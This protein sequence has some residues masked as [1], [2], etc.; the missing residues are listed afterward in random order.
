MTKIRSIQRAMERKILQIKLKDKIPHRDIGKK[1]TNFE[2]VLKQI[3][4]QKWR[5]AGHVGRMHGNGWTKRCT[6]WQ[7]REGR[8]NRGRRARRWRGDKK[9]TAGKTWMR[10]TKDREEWRR[11]SEGYVLQWTDNAYNNNNNNNNNN[12]RWLRIWIGK[13]Q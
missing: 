13:T 11:L 3:G 9:V 2:D 5:W 12:C 8:R 1:K 4:K 6:E 7:P 10:K